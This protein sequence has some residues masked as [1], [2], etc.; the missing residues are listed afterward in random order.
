MKVGKERELIEEEDTIVVAKGR[1]EREETEVI[2]TDITEVSEERGEE[3]MTV[4]V[5]RER[6][7]RSTSDS[8]GRGEER[9]GNAPPHDD[10]HDTTEATGWGG[11]RRESHE[12][13]EER[14]YS[15]LGRGRGS[16]DP[17]SRT[18]K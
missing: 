10:C 7:E 6:G 9:D 18:E 13:E 1:G 8:S 4:V 12:E 3:G 17:A 16:D 15:G 5:K 2:K 11:R 14:A